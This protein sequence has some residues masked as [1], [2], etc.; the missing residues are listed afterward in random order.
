MASSSEES[1]ISEEE[2]A[3]EVEVPPK[4]TSGGSSGLYR[5][6]K[7]KEMLKNQKAKTKDGKKERKK[8]RQKY[9]RE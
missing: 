8:K 2:T 4:P 3:K 9:N 5:A 7:M 6:L 1:D